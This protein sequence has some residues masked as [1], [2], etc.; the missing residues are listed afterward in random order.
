LVSDTEYTKLEGY[1][2]K[3]LQKLFTIAFFIHL[4]YNTVIAQNY[5]WP[6]DASR[7]LTSSFAEY[8]P[9][10]FHAGIDIKTWGRI[11]Y[12]VFAIRDGYIMRIA[13]SPYGYGRVLYH[14]LDTGE[15]AVYAHLNRFSEELENYTKQQQKR[16]GAYRINKYVSASQFPV[17]KGD[18]IGYTGASGIGSPHLHFEIR[19]ANNNP[20]NPFLLGYKVED[21]I[22]PLI[23]A[24]SITPLDFH[25]RVDSDVIPL[26]EKPVKLSDGK[27]E[28]A[29]KPLVSGNVGFAID[30]FDQANGVNHKFAVYKLD[31]YVNGIL[32]FSAKYDKFSYNVTN[33]IDLDRDFRLMN[34]GRGR[35]QKLYKD[36]FNQLPFYKP[37]GNEP[38]IVKCDSAS[39]NESSFHNRLGKGEHQLVIELYDFF[40]NLTT[41][42]GRFIIGERSQTYAK[43]RLE[44]NDQLYIAEIHDQYGNKIRNPEIMVSQD[45]GISWRKMNVNCV[46]YD[47]ASVT[48]TINEYLLKS[49]K[50]NTIVKIQSIDEYGIKS[51]PSYHIV[52]SDT[53]ESN[54]F[55]EL[56]LEK[57]FYDDYIRLKLA[58]EDLVKDVPRLFVQQ[59]GL[60]I[61]EVN[62]WQ[63]RFN[64]YIGVYQLVPGKD[65]P[66]SIDVFAK[67]PSDQ[68]LVFWDQFDIQTVFPDFGGSI[69]S[70]DGQ[71]QVSFNKA[72]VYENLFLRIENLGSLDDQNYDFVGEVYEIFPQDI[73]LK[74]SATIELKYPPEDYSPDKLAIYRVGDRR[75]GFCGNKINFQ[76]NTISCN[77]SN[78][79][80]FALIRDIDPPYIEIRTPKNNAQLTNKRPTLL[81]VVYDELSGI[82]NERSIVMRLDGDKV[83]AEYDPDA[84]TIKYKPD[85]PLLS[86][87]HT[88]SVGAT[89]NSKNERVVIR[90]FYI[91]K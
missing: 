55:T 26:V 72:S 57:D 60:P 41:L 35:F 25:S 43:F 20:T 3:L 27:Y 50:P 18:I 33:L 68:E 4:C 8:R 45:Q 28:L 69:K 90:K 15:I 76:N 83:I 63:N 86:G 78:L 46:E 30:C 64:E 31:F 48:S 52:K 67:D 79:G 66:L 87:E 75:H 32:Y 6:T 84:K 56:N 36:K 5:L 91:V 24:I 23:R 51:F 89:D 21:T 80:A 61:T 53:M 62:L 10:H 12:K 77:I 7:Y 19:D 29:A 11:G 74:R 81:A 47:S 9:G 88:V 49:I 2:L 54:S 34:R 65:G 71:C 44:N 13:V 40:G 85:N 58:V 17:K 16:K 59:I 70:K 14:K 38:G 42:S 37:S 1:V 22:P 39:A 73:P 82:A